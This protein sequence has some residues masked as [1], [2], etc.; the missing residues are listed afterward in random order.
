MSPAGQVAPTEQYNPLAVAVG[1]LRADAPTEVYGV[2][3]DWPRWSVL[4]PHVLAVMDHLDDPAV[5]ARASG[6]A[7]GRSSLLTNA[8]AYL[9]MRGR[10]VDARPL[11]ERALAIDEAVYGP[12]HRNVAIGLNYLALVL[13][14]LGRAGE[15]LPL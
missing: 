8:G 13:R 5:A 3:A 15:A 9:M 2:P 1:L 10:F 14:D 12:D 11:L 4:L 6:L 7:D